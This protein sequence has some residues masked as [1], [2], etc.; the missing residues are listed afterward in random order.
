[1]MSYSPRCI[2]KMSG[3][4]NFGYYDKQPVPPGASA[5]MSSRET[6]IHQPV[7][8]G[9]SG[10]WIPPQVGLPPTRVHMQHQGPPP[11]YSSGWPAH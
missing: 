7:R 1:M 3:Y 8:T 4:D 11:A 10:G 5:W 9:P 2:P 6:V